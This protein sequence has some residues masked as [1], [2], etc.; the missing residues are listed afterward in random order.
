[1]LDTES[2]KCFGQKLYYVQS[3]ADLALINHFIS[4]SGKLWIIPIFLFLMSVCRGANLELS[5]IKSYLA[6]D[7][8]RI[9]TFCYFP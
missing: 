1:M 3:H 8:N 6:L 9:I 5:R 2:F 7:A 4:L